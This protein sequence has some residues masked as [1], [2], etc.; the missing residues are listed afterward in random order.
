MSSDIG[1]LD[2]IET[3]IEEPSR[4]LTKGLL[5]QLP[6]GTTIR[7][8]KEGWSM[9]FKDRRLNKKGES[10]YIMAKDTLEEIERLK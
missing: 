7:K 2:Y 1:F 8:L 5:E 4:D 9:S 6:Q 10:L 3:P